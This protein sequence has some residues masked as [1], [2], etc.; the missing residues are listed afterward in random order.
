MSR[1]LPALPCT[2]ELREILTSLARGKK[3]EARLKERARIVLRGIDGVGI[4]DTAKEMGLDKDTVSLWRCRFVTAGVAG[5][6]DRPR[7]GAPR[8]HGPELRERI[9]AQLELAPPQGFGHWDGPLLASTL[10]VA[11]WRVWEILRAEGICLARRRSWCV[12]RDPDFAA[13]AADVVALYLSPP[14]N[15]IVLSVDEKPSIQAITRPAGFV[16]AGKKVVQGDKSTYKRNGTTTLFAALEVATGK[17][18]G[19][20]NKTKTRKDFLA[21]MDEVVA[22]AATG[23]VLHV[24]MDNLSTHKKCDE[25]LARHPNVKFHYTP[26]SASWLNQVEIWFGIFTRKSLKGA[27]FA[28]VEDL[29]SHIEA[30]LKA[31][32]HNPVPFAWKKREVRGTQLRNTARNFAN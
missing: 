14:E 20:A 11:A 23:K 21:F 9:L 10:E 4:K 7:T 25:W 12:S 3:I 6:Q 2:P 29:V 32:N 30:Y 15:A 31:Y 5:L 28:S 1:I 19:R 26:T 18:I 17:V 24:V 27:S 13:K 8:K 16:P 22:S